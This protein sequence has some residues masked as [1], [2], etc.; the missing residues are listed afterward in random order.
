M[1]GHF[2]CRRVVT[3]VMLT[4]AWCAL[5]GEASIANV[6][7]GSAV[8]M[9]V[10]STTIGTPARGWVRLGP[11][12]RFAGLVFFDLIK[13]TVAVA[14]EVLTPTD[15]TDEAIIHVQVPGESRLHFLLLIVAVTVTPGTAVI[16]A[17]PD[18]GALFLHLL[19]AD[20]RRDTEE[21]VRTLAELACA[22]LPVRSPSSPPEEV[23]S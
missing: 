14:G 6:L 18:T 20:R 8:A 1:R 19:H 10:S 17:D 23:S 13:S 22:A 4:F 11:L 2:T 16:D 3:V 21:H 12:V 15:R 5:W 7:S 9:V